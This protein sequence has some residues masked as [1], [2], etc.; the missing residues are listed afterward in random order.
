MELFASAG[1]DDVLVYDEDVVDEDTGEPLVSAL[2][3]DDTLG[4]LRVGTLAEPPSSAV[5]VVNLQLDDNLM[6]DLW[7]ALVWGGAPI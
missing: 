6:S 4:G 3:K 2:K 1:G 5:G 7:V